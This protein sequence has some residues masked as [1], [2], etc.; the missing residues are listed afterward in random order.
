MRLGIVWILWLC[1][2][3]NRNKLQITDKT[4]ALI[5]DWG[6]SKINSLWHSAILSLWGAVYCT[7]RLRINFRFTLILNQQPARLFSSPLFCRNVHTLPHARS[8][9]LLWTQLLCNIVFLYILISLSRLWTAHAHPV[10][11]NKVSLDL[12]G[13]ITSLRQKLSLSL[14]NTCLNHKAS[15]YCCCAL[16]ATK[17]TEMQNRCWQ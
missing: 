12:F 9:L 14:S 5:T 1:E 4:G 7:V 16:P 17:H 8:V 3:S 15:L 6:Q 10:T 2:Q 13:S 11:L